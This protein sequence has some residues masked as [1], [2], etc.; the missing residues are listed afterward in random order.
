MMRETEVEYK[1]ILDKFLKSI[2]S[3]PER[4]NDLVRLF[5]QS[6]KESFEEFF[7]EYLRMLEVV[8]RAWR[9]SVF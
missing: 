7:E 2:F 3:S 4:F 5:Y 8:V 1:V 9:E 6:G